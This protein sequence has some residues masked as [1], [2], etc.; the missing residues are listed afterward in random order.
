[1]E[2]A[3]HIVV[4]GVRTHNLKSI[5]CRIPHGAVTVI[6]GPSGSG[7][8]SLAFD[9]LYAE[10][11]RRYTESLSTYARQFL[12]Q[13][14]RP[15]VDAVDSIQPAVALRQNNDVT[16]ARSTVGTVTEI[17]DHLQ[18]IFANAGTTLCPNGH[19]E[20]T[21]DTPARTAEEVFA[22]IRGSRAVICG[23][24]E[25]PDADVRPQLLQQLAAQGYS[26][27]WL[28]DSAV[29]IADVDP[30]RTARSGGVGGRDRPRRRSRR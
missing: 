12:E 25:A 2:A 18:L 11:Q 5:D 3:T 7:K 4:R 14:S 17:D 10:G 30:E 15:P 21:R 6:T 20:V 8:S 1:M 22:R 26:R 29:E 24:V 28:D 27:I 16:N 19:G 13:M 9:T 23:L